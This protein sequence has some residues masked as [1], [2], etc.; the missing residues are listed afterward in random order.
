M[1]VNSEYSRDGPNEIQYSAVAF[2]DKEST[3]IPQPN[4]LDV[5]LRQAFVG[6]SLANY[7]RLVQA[8]PDANPFSST[9]RVTYSNSTTA[10]RS[11]VEGTQ[12]LTSGK[13]G[14]IAAASLAIAAVGMAIGGFI[15]YK[16]R[17]DSEERKSL[18]HGHFSFGDTVVTTGNDSNT[19]L[20]L[21]SVTPNTNLHT[22]ARQSGGYVDE[23]FDS[24]ADTTTYTSGNRSVGNSVG[25][26]N[27]SHGFEPMLYDDD[28]PDD[29][30][31]MG[32]SSKPLSPV[33][34]TKDDPPGETSLDAVSLS[35]S[36]PS[37][38]SSS[39]SDDSV[40][41]SDS[42]SSSS[43]DG[44]VNAQ[45]VTPRAK[46]SAKRP[47][48]AREGSEGDLGFPDLLDSGEQGASQTDSKPEV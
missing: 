29:I 40:E 18:V 43:D 6:A 17:S 44:N 19:A 36:Q 47:P 37:S 5:L 45:A 8:L 30:P 41:S 10:S 16:R 22:L 39:S 31:V 38:S 23:D 11:S 14:A 42:S 33:T 35:S 46:T 7:T 21:E 27:R 28:L 15:F 2:F 34:E 25:S 3:T 26:H 13:K 1:F 20:S 12:S 24:L 9:T 32:S 48:S 4:D